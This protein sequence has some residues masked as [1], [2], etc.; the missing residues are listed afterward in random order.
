[1]YTIYII[2]IYISV[3]VCVRAHT[4]AHTH[5]CHCI[6]MQIIQPANHKAAAGQKLPLIFTL[7]IRM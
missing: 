1:M 7:K 6:F 5:T 3:C 2:Y 4:H